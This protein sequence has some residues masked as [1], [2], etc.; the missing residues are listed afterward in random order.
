[1]SLAVVIKGP[2]GIVLAA[3]SRVTVQAT[4]VGG[5][6]TTAYFDNAT[7]LLSFHG[8]YA[9]IGAVT[10]GAAVLNL[11]T[12]NS[13]IPQF[14]AGLKNELLTVEAFAEA[15]GR[16]FMDRWQE[17]AAD[18]DSGPPM[19]FIVGGYNEE[20]P[21][22]EVYVIS[23]PDRPSP[24]PR[25]P[26]D[27]NFGMT[28]GGQLGIVSR[29]IH[30]YDPQVIQIIGESLDVGS[31]KLETL[32]S[33]LRQKVEI[34]IPYALLPLQDCVNLAT[35]M[36]R[37]TMTAQD[38]SVTLR[39]VGGGI[40]VAT[41]TSTGSLHYIQQKKLYGENSHRGGSDGHTTN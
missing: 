6:T 41:I 10:Y 9:S 16:F 18:H 37:T 17:V 19:Q 11:R 36:I 27:T 32:A 14:E 40:D 13:F 31:E 25:N 21:Y 35:F 33:T 38:L 7:K 23:V 4:P 2:E 29:L 8:R 15:L 5:S 22:G 1:M 20:A 24:E 30:G 3:D 39:G 34:P 12:A 28:W 26:V